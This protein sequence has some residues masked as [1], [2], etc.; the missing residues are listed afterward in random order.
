MNAPSVAV[1]IPFRSRGNDPLREQNLARVLTEWRGNGYEPT[2][3]SDGRSGGDAFCRSAAYNQAVKTVSADVYVFAES[4]LIIRPEAIKMAVDLAVKE[5]GLVIPFSEFRALAEKDS[6]H[7]R[8]FVADP[9][10]C[11]T[12]VVRG[13]RGS[14]GAINV[15]SRESYDLVGAYDEEFEGAWYDDDAMKIAFEICCGPTRWIGGPAYH[16]YH[17]PGGR[18]K[19]LTDEDR[20]ATMKNRIRYEQYQSAS[21]ADEI[22]LLTCQGVAKRNTPLRSLTGQ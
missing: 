10:N 11:L 5:P 21:T 18:G 16:L 8:H 4:D 15:V 17:L 2:V 14:I 1:I 12:S 20:A 7:V 9:F 19:H 22:R 6:R 13:Y 3:V